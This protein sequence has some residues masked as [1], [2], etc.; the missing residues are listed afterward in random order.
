MGEFDLLIKNFKNIYYTKDQILKSELMCL[1]LLNYNLSF[2][3]VKQYYDIFCLIGFVFEDELAIVNDLNEFY[4]S[5]NKILKDLINDFQSTY[6]SSFALAFAVIRYLR[7]FNLLEKENKRI[8]LLE[9]IFQIKPKSYEAAWDLLKKIKKFSDIDNT[10][11]KTISQLPKLKLNFNLEVNESNHSSNNLTILKQKNKLDSITYK[12]SKSLSFKI[13]SNSNSHFLKQLHE[14]NNQI[15]NFNNL[16]PLNSNNNNNNQTIPTKINN[17][18]NTINDHNF[19]NVKIKNFNFFACESD[20]YIKAKN[21]ACIID[22]EI[23]PFELKELENPNCILFKSIQS[24]AYSNYHKKPNEIKSQKNLRTSLNQFDFSKLINLKSNQILKS[25]SEVSPINDLNKEQLNCN[26][27]NKNISKYMHSKSINNAAINNYSAYNSRL[28]K[29]QKPKTIVVCN[30]KNKLNLTN[31]KDNYGSIRLIEQNISDFKLKFLDKEDFKVNENKNKLITKVNL[32]DL[33]NHKQ[34]SLYINNT[35]DITIKLSNESVDLKEN[36][37]KEIENLKNKKQDFFQIEGI[38]KLNF[39]SNSTRT[40]FLSN[41]DNR[42]KSVKN[43][44]E[45]I[46][47]YTDYIEHNDINNTLKNIQ[48]RNYSN[49]KKKVT[50]SGAYD[51]NNQLVIENPDELNDFHDKYPKRSSCELLP[52]SRFTQNYYNMTSKFK[53]S[54]NS[55]NDRNI[56]A[57]LF[58]LFNSYNKNTEKNLKNIDLFNKSK[59]NVTAIRNA[60]S[61]NFH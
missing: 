56:K 22:K 34:D 30:E 53:K 33:A 31:N 21:T 61:Y 16:N 10:K 29:L 57:D 13:D 43:R 37:L 51:V 46:N 14:S 40:N 4:E 28:A 25:V 17:F 26:N 49:N 47:H 20:R 32:N 35:K 23:S 52:S 60:I 50:F 15:N 54:G 41:N 27:F 19:E 39:N 36:I 8:N 42:N 44:I 7:E 24:R 48:S 58:D 45:T 6:Y 2:T 38:H 9:E 18:I 12:N 11:K 1:S 3:N 5:G 59:R 55:R